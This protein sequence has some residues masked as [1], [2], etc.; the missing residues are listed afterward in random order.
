MD[1]KEKGKG[2]AGEQGRGETGW[3]RKKEIKVKEIGKMS[4]E[5]GERGGVGE[6]GKQ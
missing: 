1:G 6:K 5:G 4:G 3:I 2:Q